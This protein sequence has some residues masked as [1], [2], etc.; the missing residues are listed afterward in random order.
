MNYSM[1]RYVIGT[2]VQMDGAFMLLPLI[3]GLIYS[4]P[5]ARVFALVICFSLATGYLIRGKKPLNTRLYSREG[6]LCVALSWVV[7][8]VYGSL[9]FVVSGAIPHWPDAL[10]ETVSGF[11]TT[12]ASILTDV[13]AMPRCILMWRS[14]THWI[15]GMGVLVFMLAI[16]PMSGASNMHL[17]RA[18]SPGPSVGKMLPKLRSTAF[19]CYAIYTVMTVVQIV[20]LLCGGMAPFD[21][22]TLSFGTA[23]TGGFGVL[24]ASCGSYSP[25]VQIVITVFMILFGI[26]FNVYFSLYMRRPGEALRNEEMRVYLG[27]IVAA[28]LMITFNVH[29]MFSS[30]WEALRHVSFQVGSIITTTG[31]STVDF[32]LWPSFS[33]SI[34]VSLMF[35]GAC[36]GSTG[37]GMK[38]SRIIIMAK[39]VFKQIST[40]VHPNAIKKVLLEGKR[41]EHEVVRSVN[42]FMVS[43]LFIIAVSTLLISLDNLDMVTN[44]T[45]VVATFN[46]I[47]PGLALV[48]PTGNFSMFSDLSKFVMVFDM[49]AGRLEIFPMLVLF[50]P[51]IWKRNY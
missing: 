24:N 6:F 29:S 36:A 47:G 41:V 38:I 48:G 10:F 43:Y 19:I 28:I 1:I 16:M 9:P 49:L 21:A 3:T 26:N 33:K 7:M 30:I 31:F 27:I 51:A 4:E 5:A 12:G 14:F 13:E 35:I 40:I 42:V 2:V 20:L 39:T 18:E 25:Y 34:L 46:N 23:G 44:F 50:S 22:I 8:S 11:T 37:G 45:A 15:G 17:L 32:D